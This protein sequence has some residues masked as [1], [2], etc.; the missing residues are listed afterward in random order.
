MKK[1]LNVCFVR[2]LVFMQEKLNK[3]DDDNGDEP[4]KNL[5][6]ASTYVHYLI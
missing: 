5:E 6:C 1:I 3:S 2:L 4:Q